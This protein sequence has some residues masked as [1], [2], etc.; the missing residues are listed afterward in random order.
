[1]PRKPAPPPGKQPPQRRTSRDTWVVAFSEELTRLRPHLPSR[2]AWTIG[3]QAYDGDLDAR[4][5]A[6]EYHASHESGKVAP[7]RK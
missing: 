6:R 3:V 7:A 5:A 1:M 2:L 4:S